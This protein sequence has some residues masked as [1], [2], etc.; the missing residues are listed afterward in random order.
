VNRLEKKM[1]VYSKVD[2]VNQFLFETKFG[3]E[4][5]YEIFEKSQFKRHKPYAYALVDGKEIKL[6]LEP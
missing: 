1:W 6:F 4:G 5:L 3:V 2:G